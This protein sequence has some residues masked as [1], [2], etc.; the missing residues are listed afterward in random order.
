M[1][2]AHIHDIVSRKWAVTEAHVRD[3]VWRKWAVTEAHIHD[4]V[5]RKWAVTEAHVRDKVIVGQVDCDCSVGKNVKAWKTRVQFPLKSHKVMQS[6]TKK[7]CLIA[8]TW[9]SGIV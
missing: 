4:I 5:W 7:I 8:F 9:H 3:T 1:T 2:E 6:F